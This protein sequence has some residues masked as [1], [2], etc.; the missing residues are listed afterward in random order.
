MIE[1]Y[2][3]KNTTEKKFDILF[4]HRYWYLY[5]IWIMFFKTVICIEF[6]RSDWN[7]SYKERCLNYTKKCK[8][9]MKCN[10]CMPCFEENE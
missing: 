3:Y 9:N 2:K 4:E 6:C 1:F 8:R 7:K 10:S 5:D